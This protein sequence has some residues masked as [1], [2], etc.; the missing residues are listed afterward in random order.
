MTAGSEGSDEED[1]HDDDDFERIVL[2]IQQR[3]QSLVNDKD[4]DEEEKSQIRR[5]KVANLRTVMRRLKGNLTNSCYLVKYNEG[6]LHNYLG[7][8]LLRH[9]P[10]YLPSDSPKD[11]NSSTEVNK[12]ATAP[13]EPVADSSTKKKKSVAVVDLYSKKSK[14]KVETGESRK[15]KAKLE[16][17]EG[18]L[19]HDSS[20][21]RKSNVRF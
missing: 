10:R 1:D 2:G 16:T 5:L 21:K 3:R 8:A 11:G 19:K 6:C 7:S 12:E 13:T 14:A 18:N 15:S 9:G 4:D 20:K 17:V